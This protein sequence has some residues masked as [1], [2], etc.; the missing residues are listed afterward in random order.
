MEINQDIV[1]QLLAYHRGE[2]DEETRSALKGRIETDHELAQ[3]L[4]VV[5]ELTAATRTSD[6]SLS[7]SARSLSALIIRDYL[8][9][10]ASPGSIQGV[11]VFDSSVVPLPDGVRPAAVDTRQLRYKLD[12]GDLSLALYPL[13]MNSFEMVG[14]LAGQ[15]AG[16]RLVIVLRQG[17]KLQSVEA[18]E[19]HLFRFARVAGGD[20]RLAVVRFGEE[21]AFVQIDI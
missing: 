10:K 15:P 1:R 12:V 5:V 17:R 21:I 3:L 4:A 20:S 2:L 18:D 14:Q 9:K 19:H 6:D 8:R 11:V 7:Q 13:T 16:D